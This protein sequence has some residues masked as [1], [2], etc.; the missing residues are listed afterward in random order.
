[1][2][3]LNG[4][5]ARESLE[6]V[7]ASLSVEANLCEVIK[8]CALSTVDIATALRDGVSTEEVGTVNVFGDKQ[9]EVDLVGL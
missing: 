6:K 1:M 4:P 3:H 9:L 2:V 7:L 5:V 8:A